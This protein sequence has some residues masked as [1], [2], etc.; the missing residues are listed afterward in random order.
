[1]APTAGRLIAIAPVKPR[2]CALIVA[3]MPRVAAL[4]RAGFN[5]FRLAARDVVIDLLT[6]SGTGAMSS[7]QWS[8]MM[9]GDESYAGSESFFRFETAVRD[10]TG[11]RHIL[12]THQGRAAERI[13][14]QALLQ[15]GDVTVNNIH[16]DTTR[17]NVEFVGAEARDLVIDAA[18]SP[19]LVHPFK[20]SMDVEAL[21]RVLREDGDRV[22]LVM[23]TIANNSGGDQPVSM[24]NLAGGLAG[25]DMEAIAVGLEEVL[26]ESYLAHR[27]ASVE[28]FASRLID[29]GVPIVQPAGGHGVFVDAHA[30]PLRARKPPMFARPSFFAE[31]TQPS[32]RAG[33]RSRKPCSRCLMNQA[34]SALGILAGRS[35]REMPQPRNSLLLPLHTR[36][37]VSLRP[38]RNLSVYRSISELR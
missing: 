29:A 15:P 28:A 9:R 17:A 22:R 11:Y 13:L 8:A 36:A 7:A 37:A 31:T 16:F 34:F 35:G 19:S 2:I 25:Y 4:E 30:L 24:E 32:A 18:R 38:A 12:S 23:V 27:I 21:E 6:D 14:F 26:D 1:M 10:L 20:G 33:E 3:A 5:V